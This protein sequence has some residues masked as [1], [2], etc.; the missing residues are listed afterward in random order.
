MNKNVYIA[1]KDDK[2]NYEVP[3]PRLGS[4]GG[5][6]VTGQSDDFNLETPAVVSVVQRSMK[7]QFFVYRIAVPRNECEVAAKNPAYF[8]Y[9]FDKLMAN[10]LGNYAKTVGPSDVVRFGTMYI[11]YQRPGEDADSVFRE[12]D[13]FFELRFCGDWASDVEA[14]D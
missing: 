5:T 11:S 1:P 4:Y 10:I 6:L 3:V 9:L 8:N 13:D 14:Y 12:G 7:S 2:G